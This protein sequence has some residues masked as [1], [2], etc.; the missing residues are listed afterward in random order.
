MLHESGSNNMKTTTTTI[1]R[2]IK[3]KKYSERPS[4]RTMTNSR[5]KTGQKVRKN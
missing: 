4:L 2:K 3:N 1:K 5:P